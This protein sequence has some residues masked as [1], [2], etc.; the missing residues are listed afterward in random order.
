[1]IILGSGHGH[2]DFGSTSTFPHGL[3][4]SGWLD[5]R[6]LGE[7][8]RITLTDGNRYYCGRYRAITFLRADV[9]APIRGFVTFLPDQEFPCGN[10]TAVIIEGAD[11]QLELHLFDAVTRPD[12]R[13]GLC[14]AIRRMIQTNPG[15]KAEEFQQ[16]LIN[17]ERPANISII[18]ASGL[19]DPVYYARYAASGA[20][21]VQHYYD[22]GRHEF[23]PPNFYFRAEW[24][25][26]QNSDVAEAGADP[27]LHYIQWGEGEGR[28]PG[29]DFDVKWY[30]SQYKLEEKELALAHYVANYA[31]HEVAPNSFFDLE[32]YTNKYLG[33]VHSPT[34]PYQ[35]YIEATAQSTTAH[36]FARGQVSK[37]AEPTAAPK[38]G[39]SNAL[40]HST[41][42]IDHIW[43]SPLVDKELRKTL[44]GAENEDESKLLYLKLP[45][46]LRPK[47]SLFVDHAYYIE[48]YPDLA[49]APDLDPL[50]HFINLGCE[51]GRSPH[52]LIDLG[53]IRGSDPYALSS[54]P[55][56]EEL[57][58][59]LFHDLVD[60]SPYF[61]I[62]EYKLQLRENGDTA[63]R[64]CLEHYLNRGYLQSYRPNPWFDPVW[65]YKTLE[66]VHDIWAGLRQFV[67]LGDR[68][69]RCPSAEF[70]GLR[71]RQL[72]PDVSDAGTPPLLHYICKGRFENRQIAAMHP[73]NTSELGSAMQDQHD[74]LDPATYSRLK[75]KIEAMRAQSKADVEVSPHELYRISDVAEGAKDLRFPVYTAP[76]ISILIPIYDECAITL[77]CLA[78]IAHSRLDASFEIIIA[79]DASKDEAVQCIAAIPGVRYLRRRT[80]VGFLHN[81]NDAFKDCRGEYVLLLNNDT[82]VTNGAVDR[83]ARVLDTD[84]EI[85]AVGPKILYPNGRL[86]EA[87][88]ALDRNG[89]SSMIGLFGDPEEAAYCY[90]RDVDYCSGAALM[91]RRSLVE[92]KLFDTRFAPAYCEDADLCLR[93]RGHGKRIRYCSDAVIYHHLS[94]S[95]G[96]ESTLKRLRLV[97]RNQQTLANKWS[98]ELEELNSARVIAFYLPQFH[99]TDENDYYWGKGFTEWTN[100]TKAKPAFVGHY[101][102]HLPA[103]LGF[104]DLRLKEVLEQQLALARRY[105]V[106]GFCFYYYNFGRKRAL[107]KPLEMLFENKN[108]DLRYCVCWANENW[109]RHWDGGSR[110]IIFEQQYDQGTLNSVV[111]D[112][113]K[114]A[115]DPRYIRV[116]GRPIFLV[117]RPKLIPEIRKFTGT[118][119]AKARDLG[120]DEIHLVYVESME[121]AREGILPDQLGFDASVEFPPQG[122]A[123]REQKL[124]GLLRS[125]FSGAR[126]SYEETVLADLGRPV[127]G[128]SRYPGVFPSWDNTPRQPITGT[129][130]PDATPE[131]FQVYVE[132]KLMRA[133]NFLT[134]DRRLLFVNAW[135]EWAEGAHLE[136]DRLFGHRWLE[137]LR[138]AIHSTFQG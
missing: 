69:G 91:V 42:A 102:P 52:P 3:Y 110:E 92:G 18:R 36:I 48:R 103:D 105:G 96:K 86:Q 68:E 34:D 130:F 120:L 116:E 37:A 62:E 57:T 9:P 70:D 72:N 53:H 50:I 67:L 104:Y 33:A 136:P 16:F 38:T 121:L 6:A 88:C 137:A 95:T 109:T 61:L 79:D 23:I 99:P 94:V 31:G 126:Y 132:E 82:Q 39:V 41:S 80:N 22:T 83:L 14:D 27:L 51:E 59:V 119:R 29:P 71:Y 21:L 4:L 46:Q 66:G 54:K 89:V 28:N 1:M 81:C 101:Q 97:A 43:N 98:T 75:N 8:E 7:V 17:E 2:I 118:I 133:Q 90:D 10:P 138:N 108:I 35:H 113:C 131:A 114:Y 32:Y 44:F 24:Y 56:I 106:Y 107:D 63:E 77:E 112:F 128:Y 11:T 26:R 135:N 64:G 58:D 123:V 85:G 40:R 127:P 84:F 45:I 74:R 60:P 124:S 76:K 115:T 55:S 30:K 78:S 122:H 73:Q 125:D 19:I 49:A 47:L 25:L 93:I 15:L 13:A 5:L 111:V 117:Y 134:G 87:G 65:Y 129:C 20:D 12:A 100:V